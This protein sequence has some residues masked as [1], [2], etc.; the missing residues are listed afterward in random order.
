MTR[1]HL[2]WWFVGC[3][4]INGAAL[5][6]DIASGYYGAFGFNAAMVFG[7]PW[8]VSALLRRPRLW[9]DEV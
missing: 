2:K 3:Y 4:A 6:L 1:Q 9:Q 8:L 5:A 7:L